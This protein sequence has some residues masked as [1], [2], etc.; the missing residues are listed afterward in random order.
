[1][2]QILYYILF[3]ED[4]Y[5]NFSEDEFRF[6]KEYPIPEY[7]YDFETFYILP[8]YT[9]DFYIKQECIDSYCKD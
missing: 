9:R 8:C 2:T 3:T 1:M 7:F 5:I 6:F 4:E